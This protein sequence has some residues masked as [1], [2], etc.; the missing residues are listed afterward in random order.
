MW[1]TAF[2]RFTGCKTGAVAFFY[3]NAPDNIGLFHSD[4]PDAVFSGNLFDF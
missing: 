1:L 4:D 3:L 2:K